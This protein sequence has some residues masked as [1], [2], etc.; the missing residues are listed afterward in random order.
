MSVNFANGF[1]KCWVCDVRG[2]KYLQNGKKV[3]EL[4]TTTTL[5]GTRW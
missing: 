2:K 3:W 4:P 5:V 1:F